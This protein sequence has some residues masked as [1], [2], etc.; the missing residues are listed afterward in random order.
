MVINTDAVVPEARVAAAAAADIYIRHAGDDFV[1]LIIHGSALKGDFIAGCS[2]IDFK[3]FVRDEA[4]DERGFLAFERT[5][6]IHRELAEIDPQPFGYIQCY[7]MGSRMRPGWTGQIPGAYAVVAGLVPVA[8]ATP[9]E[10]ARAAHERVRGLQVPPPYLGD[11]L[12]EHGGGRLDRVTRLI[13]TDV[14]PLLISHLIVRGHDPIAAWN[15]TKPAAIAATSPEEA[16]GRAIRDFDTA[17][18]A[19]YAATP[20]VSSALEVLQAGIVFLEA[21]RVA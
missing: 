14:W 20:R 1:G 17:V 10:L 12:L 15:L 4:L 2:D 9:E 7:A 6:A 8:D 5:V 13:C 3:L 19:H 11:N 16:V 18:R 21:V